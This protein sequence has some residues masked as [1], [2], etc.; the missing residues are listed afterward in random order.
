MKPMS[1]REVVKAL[2]AAGCR[3]VSDTGRHEKWQC[4]DG[5]HTAPLPRHNEISPTVLRGLTTELPCLP[6]GWLR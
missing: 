6:E 3:K 4:P 2:R 1:K 5:H